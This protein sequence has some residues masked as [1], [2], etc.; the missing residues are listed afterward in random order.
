MGYTYSNLGV[1]VTPPLEFAP[2][3]TGFGSSKNVSNRAAYG[4]VPVAPSIG[5]TAGN[6]TM[7]AMALGNQVAAQL[8]GYAASLGN[9]GANIKSETAAQIPADV[10]QRLQQS[11]AERGVAT[12]TAGSPNN[13]A[14]YLRALGL[15]S[16]DL[17]N[18]GQTNL[19]RQ[20][21]AL[22]G[23]GISQNPGFYVTPQQQYEADLQR[24]IFAAAPDPYAA[25]S[26]SLGAARMGLGAG[27]SGFGS[28][29]TSPSSPSDTANFMNA[30]WS[31]P[32]LIANSTAPGINYNDGTYRVDSDYGDIIA[33]NN[34]IIAGGTPDLSAE[35]SN[36]Y[37]GPD[38]AALLAE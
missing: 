37:Q 5:A 18:M 30:P 32:T 35:E 2:E 20:L 29:P 23:Y 13:D 12:G 15:T 7:Q 31:P 14:A 34:Q 28:G 6:A 8:P 33:K 38:Y 21:P 9:I 24:N 1:G 22:P 26:A 4:S 27:G 36:Y 17:T 19:L 11:A 25:A 10:L 3:P 16:L